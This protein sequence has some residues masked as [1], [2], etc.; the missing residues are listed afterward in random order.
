MKKLIIVFVAA[1]LGVCA[2]NA[3]PAYPGKQKVTQPDGSVVT[4]QLHGDEWRNF[5]TTADGYTVVKDS[6]GYFVYAEKKEG[7]LVATSR[8]AHDSEAR[9]AEDRAWLQSVPKYQAPAMKS[10]MAE[11][12]QKEGVRRQKAQAMHRNPQYDYSIF[13]GLIVLVEY[14]DQ[15]FSRL[16]YAAIINDMV[17]KEGYTGYDNTQYGRFTGSVRDYFHDNSTGLFTPQFDIVGPYQVNRSK[18]YAKQT[19][20]ATQLTYDVINLIDDDIDFSDYDRDGDGEVDMIYFIFAGAGSHVTGTQLIWPHAYTIMNPNGGWNWQVYKDGVQLGSYACSVELYGNEASTTLDGIGTICHE[21]SHV[22]GLPD[23]YDTDYEDYG[24]SDDPGDWSIMAGGSYLNNSRTPCGYSLYERYAIGFAYPQTLTAPGTYELGSIASTN[25]GFRLDTPVK[26]EYFLL[27]NRQKSDKWDQYLAGHGMLVFRVDSTSSSAWN[28]NKVN[29]NPNH[30]YYE[31]LRADGV[32]SNYYGAYA[33]GSDP[34]P[35]TKNVRVLDNNT[36]PAN[37]KTWA[38]EETRMGLKNIS[39]SDG[40]ITFDLKD[41]LGPSELLLPEEVEVMIGG[42]RQLQAVITPSTSTYVLTWESEDESVATVTDNGLVTAVAI[43][44][45]HIYVRSDN[46]LEASCLVKVVELPDAATI[47][48]FCTMEEGSLAVLH[49][50]D[51]QVLYVDGDD[52]YVRD[53]TGAVVFTSTG[54]TLHQNDILNGQVCG[55]LGSRDQMPLF[56]G[57]QEMTTA[58]NLTVTEGEAAKPRAVAFDELTSA[59]YGDLVEI[60]S[61]QLLNDDDFYIFNGETRMRITNMFGLSGLEMPAA[62]DGRLFCVKGI[63][64]TETIDGELVDEIYLTASP[65]KIGEAQ[66]KV[67]AKSYTREY[68]EDNPYFEYDTTGASLNGSPEITCEATKDSPAGTYPIIVRR[69]D[70]TNESCTYTDGTLTITPAVL[71]VKT[72]DYTRQQGQDDPT[73]E[74]SYEGF[75]N[76]E[77]VDVLTTLPQPSTTATWESA[78]GNYDIV[79]SGGEADN[80]TFNYVKGKLTVTTADP[81]KVTVRNYTRE[82]G[83]DN[84]YFEYDTTGASLNG[85]PEITCEATAESPVG[86]YPIIISKGAVRNFNDTYVNGTLTITK[87][88]LTVKAGNYTRQQG[89]DDPSFDLTYEGFKLSETADVLTVKPKA[90]TKATWESAPGNYDVVV[91]GGESGNYTFS[92]VKGTLTVT[93]A[94]PVK[95]TVGSYTREYGEENPYFEYDA[96]GVVYGSPEIICEATA[97]SPVGTYPIVIRKGEVRNFNDSYVNGTLTITKAPLTVSVK[98]AE[99]NT[100]E[101]NPVFELTYDGWKLNDSESVLTVKPVATTEATK[102]SPEGE[103]TIVVSGGEAQNYEFQYVNGKLIVHF[104]DAIRAIEGSGQTFDVYTT[105]G[106]LV[107]RQVTSLKELPRGIYIVRW[108]SGSQLIHVHSK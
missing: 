55:Q 51:A 15:S 75:K 7:E 59:D 44:E 85:S 37:L 60:S 66:T 9:S 86:T 61:T 11:A 36:S 6:R 19:D 42:T 28:N 16:N 91:S 39:E 79:I 107:G 31:L 70:V 41:N 108:D 30:N 22:L 97:E 47:R 87:A 58:A 34:F 3:V 81:V 104:V 46:G 25:E 29:S 18:Y 63:Y 40:V 80:Y 78:P 83:E 23:L 62:I 103:Y 52:C 82:Y 95:L 4:V 77:T 99:R 27:E 45:T 10:K 26:N 2:A 76:D 38:N 90:T 21:F 13:R 88:P 50:N 102:D 20:N 65:E 57:V 14:N 54:L 106:M 96:T 94:E 64:G 5:F 67:T 105:S 72:G 35:G 68:G 98:D 32:K 71:T 74:L 73:F 24:Q 49:L 101:D 43:G 56:V 12:Q 89:Q 33:A 93:T 69:G 8:V 53:K 17:N 48:D 1:L 84:P 100:G 92:Y